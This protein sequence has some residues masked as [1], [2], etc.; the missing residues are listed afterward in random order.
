MLWD[1]TTRVIDAVYD[2]QAVLDMVNASAPCLTMAAAPCFL[3]Y[4]EHAGL[5]IDSVAVSPCICCMTTNSWLDMV[6]A[7]EQPAMWPNIG[8]PADVTGDNVSGGAAGRDISTSSLQRL[9]WWPFAHVSA[10]CTRGQDHQQEQR[11]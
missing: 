3:T 8:L 1:L 9:D 4:R 5:C 7:L 2:I 10:L 11:H 6:A